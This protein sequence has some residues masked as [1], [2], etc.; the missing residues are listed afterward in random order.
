MGRCDYGPRVCGSFCSR[1]LMVANQARVRPHLGYFAAWCRVHT[2]PLVAARRVFA[3]PFVAAPR[4]RARPVAAPLAHCCVCS[5]QRHVDFVLGLPFR[6]GR[7]HLELGGD[8]SLNLTSG[9]SAFCEVNAPHW[10]AFFP[11]PD[12]PLFLPSPM[13]T[14]TVPTRQ[15]STRAGPLLSMRCLSTVITMLYGSLS[16]TVQMQCSGY[17][18]DSAVYNNMSR[19]SHHIAF[20]KGYGSIVQLFPCCHVDVLLPVSN[21]YMKIT[22]DQLD[23]AI[24]PSSNVREVNISYWVLRVRAYIRHL[25]IQGFCPYDVF[26]KNQFPFIHDFWA[27]VR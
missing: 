17:T 2:R 23:H 27:E 12:Q 3:C 19:R 25:L 22:S 16:N 5:L 10:I 15:P 8:C 21:F 13:G 18:A 7:Q 4:A 6:P 9:S 1:A 24:M 26:L 11:C 14:V 20:V